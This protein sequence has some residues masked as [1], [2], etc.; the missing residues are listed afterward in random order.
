MK[1]KQLNLTNEEK[2]NFVEK[3]SKQKSNFKTGELK[4]NDLLIQA[5]L[6]A[7][8]TTIILAFSPLTFTASI[9]VALVT[10]GVF[11]TFNLVRH[12]N[13]K[14]LINKLS[15]G[16]ITYNQYKELKISGELYKW[17]HEYKNQKF[18][19]TEYISNETDKI[20]LSVSP[21]TVYKHTQKRQEVKIISEEKI[22]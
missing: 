17:Q 3:L 6:L 13:F 19:A 12:N 21:T 10:A 9:A 20:K 18:E 11:A 2:F 5:F 14:K 8:N 22:K 1:E 4:L 15:G 7:F 16:K